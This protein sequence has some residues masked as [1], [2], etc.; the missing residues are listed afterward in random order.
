[1]ICSKEIVIPDLS[2]NP[3]AFKMPLFCGLRQESLARN[4]YRKIIAIIF[5]AFL[6]ALPNEASGHAFPDH[7]DPKVGASLSVPPSAVRVWFDSALEPAFSNIMVH[8]AH[9]EM[10]DKGDSRVNPSDPTLLEVSVPQLPPGTYRV[11]WHVV[12]R[13]GHRTEGDY[14]FTVR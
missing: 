7:S 1:M 10:V 11:I 4:V 8:N 2:P 3:V 13:D 6:C 14:T 9:E 5:L 12:A